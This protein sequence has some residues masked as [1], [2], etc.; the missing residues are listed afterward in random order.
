MFLSAYLVLCLA[1]IPPSRPDV[2]VS[3]Q[4]AFKVAN[5]PEGV[6]FDWSDG[7]DVLRG[8]VTPRAL[9]AGQELTVA[10]SVE[11]VN[12]PPRN[13]PVTVGL[14]P[15]AQLG[16]TESHTVTRAA[17]ERNW[18]VHLT[19]HEAGAHVL[20]F[21]FR[22]THLK[23]ARGTLTIGPPGLPPWLGWAV[24]VLLVVIS[25]GGASAALWRSRNQGFPGHTPSVSERKAG[26]P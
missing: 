7:E 21:S 12:G 16:G 14:R 5:T 10:F 1:E 8:L 19:P 24:G 9:R 4:A 17:G 3:P 26:E 20:D 6:T 18:V 13:V 25:V 11:P 2:G 22:G 23:T 15:E